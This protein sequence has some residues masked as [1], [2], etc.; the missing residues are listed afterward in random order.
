MLTVVH[1]CQLLPE[2]FVLGFQRIRSVFHGSTFLKVVE[3]R[4]A[5]FFK[6]L[7]QGCHGRLLG[8]NC[9]E[10][11]E[12]KNKKFH[13]WFGFSFA[14]VRVLCVCFLWG[15]TTGEVDAEGVVRGVDG[16]F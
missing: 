7:L 14:F 13:G 3:D 8:A 9:C 4:G 11:S 16:V 12:E 15:S 2:S 5:P 1:C 10:E 6:T